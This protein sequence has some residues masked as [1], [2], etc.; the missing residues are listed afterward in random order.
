MGDPTHPTLANI[1]QY[2]LNWNNALDKIDTLEQ[3]L[4]N[5]QGFDIPKEFISE[6]MGE[7]VHVYMGLNEDESLVFF[8]IDSAKDNRSTILSNPGPQSEW[9]VFQV[10]ANHNSPS[11]AMN[12]EQ[13]DKPEAMRRIANWNLNYLNWSREM[14]RDEKPL[15]QAWR[16]RRSD[17]NHSMSAYSARFAL[18]V[19]DQ[20][21]TPDLV[22]VCKDTYTDAKRLKK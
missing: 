13:L 11:P 22:I 8:L 10:S 1:S 6:V 21:C 4:R 12:S 16:I 17:L 5:C 18:V 3:K 14:C 2:I 19:T 7:F 20:S 9:P 15:F